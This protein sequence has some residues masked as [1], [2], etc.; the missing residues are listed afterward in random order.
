MPNFIFDNILKQA[1]NAVKYLMQEKPNDVFIKS[2]FGASLN[3]MF[4]EFI[5]GYTSASSN[6]FYIKKYDNLNIEVVNQIRKNI[7]LNE[8]KNS[9]TGIPIEVKFKKDA[10]S[11]KETSQLEI[12]MFK[13]V[14]FTSDYTVTGRQY[15]IFDSNSG[16][17]IT[18]DE[19]EDI[20][21]TNRMTD[22]GKLNFR[23]N[24]D[25]LR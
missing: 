20:P 15:E 24:M 10:G 3:E 6:S 8:V 17:Y 7:G 12:G 16:K 11:N 21:G 22:E 1:G 14:N 19:I 25:Y 2:T 13:N 23:F 5:K 9:T 18:V 4:N